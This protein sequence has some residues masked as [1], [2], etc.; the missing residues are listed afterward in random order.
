MEVQ[1]VKVREYLDQFT[2]SSNISF[3]VTKAV[4]DEGSPFFHEEY[5]T[6][7]MYY[8]SNLREL[9][10]AMDMNVLNDHQPPIDWLCGAKWGTWYNKGWLTS[11]L[12]ISDEDIELLYGKK[13]SESMLKYIEKEMKKH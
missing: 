7:P 3:I 4:K 12:I 5:H 2:T 8:V 9:Q 6:S 13:Q 11:M 10:W 1:E